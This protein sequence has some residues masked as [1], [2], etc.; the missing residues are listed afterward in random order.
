MCCPTAPPSSQGGSLGV[1]YIRDAGFLGISTNR[2]DS[3]YGI[4]GGHGHAEE[5]GEGEEE[6]GAVRVDLAQRR[7]DLRGGFT[8]PFGRFRGAKLRIGA[9]DYEHV[10]LEGDEIGTRLLAMKAWEGRLGAAAASQA[11][12]AAGLARCPDPASRDFEAI[13]E[14]VIRA[15]DRRPALALFAYE[16]P[17]AAR[18]DG[19][20]G[21][22]YERQTADVTAD[23]PSKPHRRRSSAPSAGSSGCIWQPG[24]GYSDWP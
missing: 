2:L 6:E 9:A 10:E 16:R 1:S 15:A 20:S 11:G 24:E 13:G 3:L 19:L 22:R 8:G 5:G 17:A 12:A 21:G 23:V 14:E 4:P 7:Y 18:L